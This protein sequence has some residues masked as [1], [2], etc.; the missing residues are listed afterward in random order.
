MR[1]MLLERLL[2]LTSDILSSKQHFLLIVLIFVEQYAECD[3]ALPY[4]EIESMQYFFIIL[5]RFGNFTV[6]PS[7]CRHSIIIPITKPLFLATCINLF[8]AWNPFKVYSFNRILDLPNNQC[9]N[10]LLKLFK[11]FLLQQSISLLLELLTV[12]CRYFAIE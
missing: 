9:R 10:L 6:I 11:L 4:V 3:L 2:H 1:F 12:L 8:R 5:I 7:P